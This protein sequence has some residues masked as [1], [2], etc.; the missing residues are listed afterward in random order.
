MN[1]KSAEHRLRVKEHELLSALANL[2]GEVRPQGEAEVRDS[3]DDATS[4]QI[5]SE[6]LEEATLLTQTLEEVRDSLHRLGEGS[7]GKCV[8][9]GRP[10]EPARLKAIP[11]TPYCL[12]DQQKQD[13]KKR[14]GKERPD[15][16]SQY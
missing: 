13:Q 16:L 7:Y 12:D 3:I 5:T 10:I 2:K 8:A 6:S 14:P 1:L 9:C 15:G 11:W 4:S